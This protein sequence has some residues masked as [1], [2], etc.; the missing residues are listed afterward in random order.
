M[1]LGSFLVSFSGWPSR[2]SHPSLHDLAVCMNLDKCGR[3]EEL[4]PRRVILG[5]NG[6][7]PGKHVAHGKP[8][9]HFLNYLELC[10]L[11]CPLIKSLLMAMNMRSGWK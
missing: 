10:P 4:P 3:D 8:P 1:T 9:R 11:T 7:I 2:S 6:E 5:P